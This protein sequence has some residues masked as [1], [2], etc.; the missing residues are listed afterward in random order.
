MAGVEEKTTVHFF[1]DKEHNLEEAGTVFHLA[2]EQVT[3]AV[4]AAAPD[5]GAAVR[6]TLHS[7][8]FE[9]SE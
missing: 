1:T 9:R 3:E 8:Q 6:S 2:A 7:F 4:E 5:H